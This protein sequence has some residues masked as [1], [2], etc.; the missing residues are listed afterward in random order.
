MSERP[1]GGGSG[2]GGDETGR[3]ARFAVGV[4]DLG[5]DALGRLQRAVHPGDP[6]RRVLAGEV[7]AALDLAH[8]REHPAQLA[9]LG[10]APPAAGPRVL[11]PGLVGDADDLAAMPGSSRRM[12][13]RMAATR[14]WPWRRTRAPRCRTCRRGP[15]RAAGPPAGS[16]CSRRGRPSCRCRR[17]SGRRAARAGRAPRTGC[18]SG[19]SSARRPCT[20][21]CGSRPSSAARTAWRSSRGAAARTAART[22]TGRRGSRAGRCGRGSRSSPRASPGRSARPRCGTSR[23]GRARRRGPSA[24]GRC[25]P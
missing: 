10:P 24:G 16:W 22:R 5:D 4:E 19:S 2:R 20:G 13:L 21:A 8:R 17:G 11:L 1:E 15:S 3:P 23:G 7:D 25:R 12:S 14:R 18:G 6:Q 9:G